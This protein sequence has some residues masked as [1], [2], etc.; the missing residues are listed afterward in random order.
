M[1][2]TA[3]GVGAGAA[4]RRERVDVA[5]CSYLRLSHPVTH[6]SP[7]CRLDVHHAVHLLDG[8]TKNLRSWSSVSAHPISWP[9]MRLP[10]SPLPFHPY[11]S[12]SRRQRT[13]NSILFVLQSHEKFWN[14]LASTMGTIS[15]QLPQLPPR[16][17]LPAHSIRICPHEQ[18]LK[19]LILLAFWEVIHP[20]Q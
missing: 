18:H 20:R 3:T 7:K 1:L 8:P 16:S 4:P 5:R 17:N 19:H 10:W 9:R 15:V 6:E 14:M 12:G 13:Q 11:R 2:L